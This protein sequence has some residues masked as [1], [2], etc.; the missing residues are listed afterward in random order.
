VV[1]AEGRIQML[2]ALGARR[3]WF[4]ACGCERNTPASLAL[5]KEACCQSLDPLP[6]RPLSKLSE[7]DTLPTYLGT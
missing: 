4:A 2:G 7:K 5:G 6:A 1:A 3:V